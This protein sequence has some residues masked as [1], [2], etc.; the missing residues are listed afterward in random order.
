MD[1]INVLTIAKK[2]IDK[3]NS[4]R[5]KARHRYQNSEINE[6]EMIQAYQDWITALRSYTELKREYYPQIQEEPHF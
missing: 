1:D 2:R 4:A 3:L 5:I 6:R